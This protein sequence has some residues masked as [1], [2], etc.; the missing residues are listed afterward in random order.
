MSVDLKQKDEFRIWATDRQSIH[1]FDKARKLQEQKWK[2]AVTTSIIELL[3]TNAR[4]Q[5]AKCLFS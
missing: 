3:Q 2:Y 4:E 1:I 5:G